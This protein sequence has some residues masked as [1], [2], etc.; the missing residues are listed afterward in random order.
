MEHRP[1]P[2]TTWPPPAGSAGCRL[3][4]AEPDPDPHRRRQPRPRPSSPAPGTPL[5]APPGPVPGRP[6]RQPAHP[7]RRGLA[8]PLGAGCSIADAS[9]ATTPG[10]GNAQRDSSRIARFCRSTAGRVHPVY[11]LGV[12]QGRGG[13]PGPLWS[14]RGVGGVG[15]HTDWIEV[16]FMGPETVRGKGGYKCST[17]AF[18]V[19]AP[20]SQRPTAP[21]VYTQG[22]SQPEARHIVGMNDHRVPGAGG[23]RSRQV[24]RHEQS[25]ALGLIDFVS[26]RRHEGGAPW[27]RI[28]GVAAHG[29]NRRC[30][31]GCGVAVSVFYASIGDPWKRVKV[32]G[33]L[34]TA[35]RT[36]EDRHIVRSTR[37]S[38]SATTA[39][40]S[41][42]RRRQ[43]GLSH[44]GGEEQQDDRLSL[45]QL[46]AAPD[47]R[48]GAWG[49]ATKAGAA[50]GQVAL[51]TAAVTDEQ[52]AAKVSVNHCS[53]AIRAM[54][55]RHGASCTS[56]S[57]DGPGHGR[58]SL[59]SPRC[60]R[61]AGGGPRHRTGRQRPAAVSTGASTE[62]PTS[63][64]QPPEP[65]GSCAI[66]L[67]RGRCEDRYGH[68]LGLSPAAKI[69][70]RRS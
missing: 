53:G 15:V 43:V 11:R 45:R 14:R 52:M 69:S 40:V 67:F 51:I 22:T 38:P 63:S 24:G 44:A 65:Y 10:S 19:A 18:H 27:L 20:C 41:L 30:Q 32:A 46:S 33:Q 26:R 31:P 54:G 29:H 36:V 12:L 59:K 13:T 55:S 42:S 34:S 8:E 57:T 4:R 48:G 6:R 25:A 16:E 21:V 56:A 58:A 50:G 49:A 3:P 62:S 35:P 1:R 39:L 9:S 60:R 47:E 2:K 64:T 70:G 28:D 61:P 7:W 17:D 66:L 5:G 37:P 23:D 68:R